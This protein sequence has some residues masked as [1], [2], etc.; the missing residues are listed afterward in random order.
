M[1]IKVGATGGVKGPRSRAKVRGQGHRSRLGAQTL[2]FL[3]TGPC[4]TDRETAASILTTILLPE[5]I[6]SRRIKLTNVLIT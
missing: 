4:P 5:S 2:S 3:A 6:N 1:G